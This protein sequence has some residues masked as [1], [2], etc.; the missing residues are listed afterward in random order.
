LSDKVVFEVDLNKFQYASDYKYL[1]EEI[2]KKL[3]FEIRLRKEMEAND[4]IYNYRPG[5]TFD[6]DLEILAFWEE[7][8]NR[9]FKEIADK[10]GI[11]EHTA[12]KALYRIYELIYEKEYHPSMSNKQEISSEFPCGHCPLDK[13]SK[14]LRPC[15]ALD[16]YLKSDMKPLYSNIDLDSNIIRKDDDNR[17]Y[18]D[19][20]AFKNWEEEKHSNDY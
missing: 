10:F 19:Q 9:P 2:K 4:T 17:E 7:L 18:G 15:S 3:K 14:C 12:K 16:A 1:L 20:A 8:P 5:K 6:R 11:S 13:K